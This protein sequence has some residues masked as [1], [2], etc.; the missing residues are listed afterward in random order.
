[1]TWASDL[2]WNNTGAALGGIGTSS[3]LVQNIFDPATNTIDY[4]SSKNNGA[5]TFETSADS[6]VPNNPG[7]ALGNVAMSH[8][9]E[10]WKEKYR[11]AYPNYSETKINEL[12][13]KKYKE[14]KLYESTSVGQQRVLGPIAYLGLGVEVL[15]GL[16]YG[17]DTG[18]QIYDN[19]FFMGLEYNAE[20]HEGDGDNSDNIY[21]NFN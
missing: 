15:A 16:Y 17:D 10:A 18:N 14:T 1:M 9:L 19:T 13:N 3:M 5:L 7:F 20:Q 2:T 4:E 12:A 6:W 11:N 8:S 21:K